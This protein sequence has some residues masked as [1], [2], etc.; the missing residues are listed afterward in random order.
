[1]TW[2]E[3]HP[4]GQTLDRLEPYHHSGLVA[5]TVL[6][7]MS[8]ISSTALFIYL[9]CKFVAWYYTPDSQPLGHHTAQKDL[10]RSTEFALGIDGVFSE[11]TTGNGG[12]AKD[13][14]VPQTKRAKRPP[15]Q[16]LV[17]I[18]NLLLADMHQ[19]TAFWLNAAWLSQSGIYVGTATC[20]A[21]GLFVSLGDL[22]SSVFITGIAVHT[23]L[24][25]VHNYRPPPNVL[26]LCITAGWIFVY[27][28]SLI[29][30]AATRNG[31]AIG[32]FFVR[33]GAWCWMNRQYD[34]LRLVTHY[35]FIFMGIA[36]TSTLYM[37]IYI[38]LRRQAAAVKAKAGKT[39]DNAIHL[40]HN[41]LFL[42]YPV[43]YV[44][45]T[46]PLAT[47]RIA[48]M[49][50]A[51]VPV[52]YFCFAGAM[53]ASNGFWDCLLF[54]TTRH[55]VIFSSEVDAEEDGIQTF[56]FMHSS[57][58]RGLGHMVSIQGGTRAPKEQTAGGWW[59]FR[60]LTGRSNSGGWN[61]VDERSTSQESL[62]GPAIQ[63]ETVTT[64][65]IEVDKDK[66]RDLR[67]PDSGSITNPSLN[68]SDK[69]L[70]R[71]RR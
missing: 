9:G 55:V 4:D 45:C 28:I 43:I 41:P 51:D 29:P 36:I 23:Y 44:L 5:I 2:G 57:I 71:S 21:Q 34:V 50:G 26:Y 49:A 52:G 8:F 1:M 60:Q 19:A 53:I 13:D 31:E 37:L 10:Q 24:S 68:S 56:N 15:N 35:L 42:L 20:F 48:T 3:L 6:A 12:D 32:G 38:S 64:V 70:A 30:V 47:G 18:F 17:L 27:T 22:A 62:R 67:Y 66:E 16:F 33:A 69:E 54:G 11:N 14:I 40:S 46:L 25:V 61:Q 58:H 63:M 7:F 39:V 59:T 65:V